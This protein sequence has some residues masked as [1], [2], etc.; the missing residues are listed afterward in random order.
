MKKPPREEVAKLTSD[1]M[2]MMTPH[3]VCDVG[4]VYI[5]MPPRIMIIPKMSPKIPS[6]ATVEPTAGAPVAPL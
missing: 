1:S 4:L 2:I 3:M 5:M 6:M